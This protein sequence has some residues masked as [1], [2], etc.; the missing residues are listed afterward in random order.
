MVSG[1]SCK[2]L[3]GASL[4]GPVRDLQ[5]VPDTIRSKDAG[6]ISDD[7]GASPSTIEERP[8]QGVVYKSLETIATGRTTEVLPIRPLVIVALLFSVVMGIWY[9]SQPSSQAAADGKPVKME[10]GSPK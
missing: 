4:S 10:R 9:L 8:L 5:R 6:I 7:L 1:T 3:T 2:S